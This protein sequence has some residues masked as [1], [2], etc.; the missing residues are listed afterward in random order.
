MKKTINFICV[1]ICLVILSGCTTITQTQEEL[2]QSPTQNKTTFSNEQLE[3][4]TEPLLVFGEQTYNDSVQIN[5][6]DLGWATYDSVPN[7][8][9]LGNHTIFPCGITCQM[10]DWETEIVDNV[11]VSRQNKNIIAVSIVDLA[12][13]SDNQSYIDEIVKLLEN[14]YN[15][16]LTQESVES[17]QK[18][19]NYWTLAKGTVNNTTKYIFYMS[20]DAAQGFAFIGCWDTNDIYT[21]ERMQFTFEEILNTYNECLD[22]EAESYVSEE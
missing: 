18:D 22:P 16:V 7:E 20:N 19:Y 5:Q 17:V 12:T 3:N 9:L 2:P 8:I 6:K 4:E 10:P 11:A 21:E 1:I 15:L 14:N 13:L